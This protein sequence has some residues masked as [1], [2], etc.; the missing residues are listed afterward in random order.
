MLVCPTMSGVQSK[1][2]R[3]PKEQKEKPSAD[4]ERK[5]AASLGLKHNEVPASVMKQFNALMEMQEAMF[6]EMRET[7]RNDIK[8]MLLKRTAAPWMTLL[9]ERLGQQEGDAGSERPGEKVQEE[10]SGTDE[11]TGNPTVRS[12]RSGSGLDRKQDKAKQQLYSNHGGKPSPESVGEEK[13][14]RACP[15]EESR[16]QAPRASPEA[17]AGATLRLAA[18]FSAA[19]LDIGGRWG[20]VFRR[21][22][23]KGLE[24]ELQCSMKLSFKCDGEAQ[25]FS[26]LQS[27]R[28]FASRKLFLRELLKDVFPQNEMRNEGGGRQELRERLVRVGVAAVEGGCHLRQP[29]KKKHN[30]KFLILSALLS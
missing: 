20:R 29:L 30:G 13:A 7:Y 12:K 27:L 22:R 18:D 14:A 4:R 6:A 23:E 10:S 9:E 26:D 15:N 8:E 11:D 19:T 2:D 1:A 25:V 28:Q 5:M 17:A 3:L 16:P 21:L 24:P